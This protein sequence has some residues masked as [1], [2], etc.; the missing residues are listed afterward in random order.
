MRVDFISYFILF[1]SSLSISIGFY[2]YFEKDS[3]NNYIGIRNFENDIATSILSDVFKNFIKYVYMG[4]FFINNFELYQDNI[5]SLFLNYSLLNRSAYVDYMNEMRIHYNITNEDRQKY[6]QFMNTL[7]GK[8]NFT[9]STSDRG[10]LSKSPEYPFYCPITLYSPNRTASLIPYIGTDICHTESYE[11][12]VED[13]LRYEERITIVPRKIFTTNKTALDFG[14]KSKTNRGIVIIT[15]ILDDILELVF[16]RLVVSKKEKV[17][18]LFNVSGNIV[19]NTQD[20]DESSMY[21]YQNVI[22]YNNEEYLSFDIYENLNY[23]IANGF[24]FLLMSIF[25]VDILLGFSIYFI[26]QKINTDAKIKKMEIA[27]MML[28][29]INHEIRNPL[30]IIK[31][32]TEINI[33][34]MDEKAN[35]EYEP[36]VSNLHTVKNACVLLEHIVND[37]LDISRIT[38]NKFI[39]KYSDVDVKYFEQDLMKTFRAKISEKSFIE[40]KLINNIHLETIHID[41]MRVKQILLNFITNAFKFTDSGHI[42]LRM[43]TTPE[44]YIFEVEDTGR[45]IKKENYNKIFKP[46]EQLSEMDSLRHGGLGLGLYLCKMIVEVL[47]GDIYFFSEE[48]KGS[49]FGIKLPISI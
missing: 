38:R 37:T 29:Y 7:L 17:Y 2:F 8:D 3:Y 24:Y 4:E 34:E 31:G 47:Q 46:Y 45:G 44:F 15:F 13:L 18:F 27:N 40:F 28:S 42:H 11:H 22:Y 43:S 5:D 49:T 21:K 41:E 39:V 48:N 25:L 23:S 16:N 12:I 19:T 33:Y 30:N 35:K 36:I 20:I 9:I 32:L 26:N 6:E 1:I 14:K 10:I